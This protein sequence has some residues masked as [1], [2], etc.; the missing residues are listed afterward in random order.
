M[1]VTDWGLW[2]R[3]GRWCTHHPAGRYVPSFFQQLVLMEWD[4]DNDDTTL[5]DEDR[6]TRLARSTCEQEHDVVNVSFEPNG[7]AVPVTTT[8]SGQ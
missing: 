3:P 5:D 8:S 1:T 2:R 7:Q 6:H 4:R